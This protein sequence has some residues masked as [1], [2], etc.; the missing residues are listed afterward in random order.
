MRRLTVL[1]G[2]DWN[3]GDHLA[4]R[5]I[6]VALGLPVRALPVEGN[7]ALSP[8][9]RQLSA[10]DAVVV[11]G[12]GL[13][14]G[15]FD[16]FW[17][18]L[19]SSLDRRVPIVVWGVGV[20]DVV[21]RD[22]VGDRWLHGEIARRSIA[23]AV[24]DEQSADGLPGDVQ[25][26]ACPAHLA[27][28][29]LFRGAHRSCETLLYLEHPEL[30]EAISQ[31]VGVRTVGT[32]LAAQISHLATASGRRFDAFDNRVARRRD[33]RWLSGRVATRAP[34]VPRY[35]RRVR[36]SAVL[37]A[38]SQHYLPADLIVTS[39][40]HGA[41][42]GF[43]LGKPVVALS[44]DRK[45]D[46]Y[47]GEVDLPEYV[48]ASPEELPALAESFRTQPSVVVHV[49][50]ICVANQEFAAAVLERLAAE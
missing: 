44:G 14:K 15:S 26:V 43:A 31:R 29:E 46:S 21:G 45:I 34:G 35:I 27:V 38:V 28:R 39:R 5:G 50:R 2:N 22:T 12:G 9:L 30:L 24:R 32:K 10:D 1:Y 41:I 8:M 6:E 13:F 3:I 16:S 47:F 4:A 42:I 48:T 37:A 11:G 23:C 18:T 40:L 20:C 25:I 36:N 49:D 7:V 19:L 17:R 33:D